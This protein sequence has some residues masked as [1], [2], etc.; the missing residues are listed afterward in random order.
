M[1]TPRRRVRYLQLHNMSASASASYRLVE[2]SVEPELKRRR[3]LDAGGPVE[4]EAT[5]RQKMRNAEVYTSEG[6]EIVG[7]DPENVRDR[8]HKYIRDYRRREEFVITA[9][10]YFAGEEDLKM[11]RW[12]YVNGADTRDEDVDIW[13]PMYAAARGGKIHA[14]KWLAEH[15]AAGDVK[16]R[17]RSDFVGHF[18]PLQAASTFNNDPALSRWLILNGALYK[19]GGAGALDTNLLAEDLFE[20]SLSRVEMLGWVNEERQC[21]KDFAVF[22]RGTLHIPMPSPQKLL[23]EL[24]KRIRSECAAKRI[25]KN[26]PAEQYELLWDELYHTPVKVLRGKRG[27]LELISEFAGV[28]HGR[29][30]SIIRQLREILPDIADSEEEDEEESWGDY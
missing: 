12:L 21:R 8:K 30:A 13:F 9:M 17:C 22:L 24:T 5:A 6:D 14:C 29:E 26:T 7:F 3:L 18:R 16:R 11:M 15:G 10:G 19:D 1:P 27:I 4:D 28:M 23:S 2:D 20:S 25:L